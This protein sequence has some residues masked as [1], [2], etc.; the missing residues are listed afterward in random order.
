MTELAGDQPNTR[1]DFDG[2]YLSGLSGFENYTG[3]IGI[4]ILSENPFG[5]ENGTFTSEQQNN[6][7]NKILDLNDINGILGNYN[8]SENQILLGNYGNF[9]F[10]E[11]GTDPKGRVI[12]DPGWI[13]VVPYLNMPYAGVAEPDKAGTLVYGGTIYLTPG[14]GNATISHEFGHIF[15]G[16]G[17]PVSFG[18]GQSIMQVP[19]TLSTTGIADKKAGE[20]IYEETFMTFPPLVYP[21]IDYLGNILGLGFYGES[22]ITSIV[23]EN[24]FVAEEDDEEIFIEEHQDS[25]NDDSSDNDDGSDDITGIS[26]SEKLVNNEDTSLERLVNNEDTSYEETIYLQSDVN[27]NNIITSLSDIIKQVISFISQKLES[28]FSI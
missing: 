4:E 28:I 23:S 26:N 17:H 11:T 8:I 5:A 14:T 9:D 2:E 24:Y 7:K 13:I 1:F 22:Q 21:R 25:H 3:L 6:I 19:T 16:S 18:S 10:Y 20:L 27:K 15:I 12:A